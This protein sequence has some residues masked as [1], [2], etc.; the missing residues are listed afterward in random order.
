MYT[1]FFLVNLI[2]ISI[3]V[4]FI[5]YCILSYE[6][7]LCFYT[8]SSYEGKLHTLKRSQI[9]SRRKHLVKALKKDS[10]FP[11]VR[12]AWMNKRHSNRKTVIAVSSIAVAAILFSL[13]I[14]LFTFFP[15]VRN[16]GVLPA[17]LIIGGPAILFMAIR[18]A[19]PLGLLRPFWMRQYL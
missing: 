7:G 9:H 3:F 1:A 8:G 16:Y 6:L 15:L 17:I 13:P 18:L 14:G 4:V 19:R 2:V 12:P 11:D 5:V 10:Y